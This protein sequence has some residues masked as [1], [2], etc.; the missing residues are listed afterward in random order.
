MFILDIKFVVCILLH[1]FDNLNFEVFVDHIQHKVLSVCSEVDAKGG[2]TF[3][4]DGLYVN[5]IFIQLSVPWHSFK[6]KK[7]KHVQWI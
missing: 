2:F 4:R 5:K 1:L 7:K 3:L 6:L